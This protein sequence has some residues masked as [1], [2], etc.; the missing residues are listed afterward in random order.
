MAC[1]RYNERAVYGSEWFSD[2]HSFTS[3][4]PLVAGPPCTERLRR[5]ELEAAGDAAVSRAVI[6][7]ENCS[8][9]FYIA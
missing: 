7:V 8:R 9:I 3:L 2:A 6:T 1:R 4:N 5:Y